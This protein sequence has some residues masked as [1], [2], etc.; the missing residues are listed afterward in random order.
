MPTMRTFKVA[1]MTRPTRIRLRRIRSRLEVLDQLRFAA[2]MR[3]HV[4]SGATSK[5]IT[6]AS[7][8]KSP[9]TETPTPGR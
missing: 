3:K 5:A 4:R 9:S 8:A 1:Y 7:P 6:E 2:Y